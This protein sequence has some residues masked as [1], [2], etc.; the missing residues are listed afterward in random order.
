[1]NALRI[2]DLPSCVCDVVDAARKQRVHI[3]LEAMVNVFVHS[4]DEVLEM[5]DVKQ[6][7][8]MS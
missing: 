3:D 8:S 1:M 2:V 4:V 5:H 6:W 7:N